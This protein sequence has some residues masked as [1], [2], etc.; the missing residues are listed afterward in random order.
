MIIFKHEKQKSP[1]RENGFFDYY[2][3][4]FLIGNVSNKR[5]TVIKMQRMQSLDK[6]DINSILVVSLLNLIP[7]NGS[8]KVENFMRRNAF[9]SA[10][11]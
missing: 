1:F 5:R 2:L 10:R 4:A 9:E 6:N 3:V 8:Y 11:A 7:L